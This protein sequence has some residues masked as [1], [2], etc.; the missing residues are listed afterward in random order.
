MKDHEQ[1][2]TSEISPLSVAAWIIAKL[3]ESLLAR[4]DD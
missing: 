4:I 1:H 3:A 2:R